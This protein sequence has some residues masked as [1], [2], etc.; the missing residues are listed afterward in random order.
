MSHSPSH[1]SCLTALHTKPAI[2]IFG[3]INVETKSNEFHTQGGAIKR[4]MGAITAHV[5]LEHLEEKGLLLERNGHHLKLDLQI[6]DFVAFKNQY[7]EIKDDGFSQ[8]SN[9]HSFAGDRRFYISL[10]AVEVDED[11]FKAR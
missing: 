11:R 1:P 6:G 3:R 4:G 5:Y 7:Y 2:E 8:I 10:K 9:E